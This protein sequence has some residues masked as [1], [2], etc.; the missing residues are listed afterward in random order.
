M[1]NP[2]SHYDPDGMEGLTAKQ[3]QALAATAKSMVDKTP[4]P[5]TYKDGGANSTFEHADCNGAV[6][7]VYKE[8][9]F[10]FANQ[11]ADKRFADSTLPGGAN[12]GII[13]ELKDQSNPQ[14]C[15]IGLQKGHMVMFAEKKINE[16]G[17]VEIWVYSARRKGK[18]YS[19]CPLSYFSSNGPVTW[20]TY[21]VT[22]NAK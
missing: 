20:Y 3:R 18:K 6:Y 17:E 9:G 16:K 1:N 12:Y 10:Y 8:N 7:L 14:L 19:L 2:L 4:Y 21:E 5:E 15:D 11:A 13:V 22:G